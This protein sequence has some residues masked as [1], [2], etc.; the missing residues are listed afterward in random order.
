[1]H[2]RPRRRQGDQ[3]C[4]RGVID[5]I[6]GESHADVLCRPVDRDRP[7]LARLAVR[8]DNRGTQ[9]SGGTTFSTVVG[10]DFLLDG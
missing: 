7:G 8:S 2:T 4:P 5:W 3:W 10:N 9:Q 6:P 1:M